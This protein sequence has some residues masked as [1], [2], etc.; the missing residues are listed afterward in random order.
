MLSG[1]ATLLAWVK[2]VA[3]EYATPDR[4]TVSGATFAPPLAHSIPAIHI[5][6]PTATP[7]LTPI[8]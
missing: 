8:G 7:T 2:N 4:S 3:H 5:A 1:R 6:T